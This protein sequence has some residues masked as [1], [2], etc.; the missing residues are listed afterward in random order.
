MRPAQWREMFREQHLCSYPNC[1]CF[2]EA[3]PVAGNV[4]GSL[5]HI[6]K[7]IGC[8]NEARPVAGNVPCLYSVFQAPSAGFN[9]ARPVAGNVPHNTQP[10]V[11]IS[12]SASCTRTNC[13]PTPIRSPRFRS[14][15]SLFQALLAR[16]DRGPDFTNSC[17]QGG[18]GSY[19]LF[20]VAVKERKNRLRAL[21]VISSVSLPRQRGRRPCGCRGPA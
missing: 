10:I 8:F 13:K 5:I 18:T 7:T 17:S 16:Y 6:K 21:P 3:R 14:A 9:E 4:P 11:L 1:Q 2:N 12:I 15:L 19:R 20:Y